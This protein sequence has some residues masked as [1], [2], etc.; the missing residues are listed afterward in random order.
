MSADF[1]KNRLFLPFSQESP[2]NQGNG[3]GVAICDTLVRNIGG[4]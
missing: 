1:V 4:S 3:L 2:F